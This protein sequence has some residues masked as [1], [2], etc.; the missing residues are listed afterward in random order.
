M[1]NLHFLSDFP[2]SPYFYV[3]YLY[4]FHNLKTFYFSVNAPYNVPKELFDTYKDV[5]MK[6]YD[7]IVNDIKENKE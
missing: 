7:F 1:D 3:L 5:T 2:I 6:Y 4:G